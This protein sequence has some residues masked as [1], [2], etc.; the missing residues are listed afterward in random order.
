MSWIRLLCVPA[1]GRD[2]ADRFIIFTRE[3]ADST[4][5]P[6]QSLPLVERDARGDLK[7][8]GLPDSE[9]DRLVYNARVFKTHGPDDD[10]WTLPFGTR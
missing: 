6:R 2:E 9:V 8:L 4:A 5:A 3:S 7:R 10:W 1:E